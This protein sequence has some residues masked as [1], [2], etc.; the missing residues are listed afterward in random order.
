MTDINEL[1]AYNDDTVAE[2]FYEGVSSDTE[3]EYGDDLRDDEIDAIIRRADRVYNGYDEDEF[4]DLHSIDIFISKY[5][6]EE[7]SEEQSEDK[8]AEPENPEEAAP[9]EVP[10]AEEPETVGKHFRDDDTDNDEYTDEDAKAP[11][12]DGY[13]RYYDDPDEIDLEI[14]GDF[15]DGI[16]A[17]DLDENLDEGYYDETD[18]E[19]SDDDE[20]VETYEDEEYYED[21][22]GEE[23][24]PEEGSAAGLKR[25]FM[26]MLGFGDSGDEEF[27]DYF[28][29]EVLAR[30]E[31]R[32]EKFR[33]SNDFFEEAPSRFSGAMSPKD[34]E[35]ADGSGFS[36]KNEVK[37]SYP[38]KV[39]TVSAKKF[40]GTVK[41]AGKHLG[42]F[43]ENVKRTVKTAVAEKKQKK[44]EAE[45]S[46]QEKQEQTRAAQERRRAVNGLLKVHRRGDAKDSRKSSQPRKSRFSTKA[47][48]QKIKSVLK[49]KTDKSGKPSEKDGSAQNK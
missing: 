9:D 23:D 38:V 34:A 29:D 49:S 47:I 24:Y 8:S 1:K 31:A 42:Y 35:Y 17:M 25:G 48:P 30:E 10:A 12:E 33:D 39:I 13:V 40:S 5:S 4:D 19:I 16:D 27:D 32:Q 37:Q 44:S 28:N 21:Y 20:S 43:A 36:L 46:G 41:G 6:S 18:G 3:E 11:D 14:D 26:S 2:D 7:F 15:Y 45:R 22:E